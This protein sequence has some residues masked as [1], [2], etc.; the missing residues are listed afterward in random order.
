[1]HRTFC[2][3]ICLFAILLPF[4]ST[5]QA[6]RRVALVIGNGAYENASRLPNP[7]HD[8]KDVAAALRRS[9]FKT[10]VGLDL[11]QSQ[12]Q[13][14]AIR[15]SRA[16]READVALFY[17]S[18]HAMQFA[19]I[20]YLMPVDAKLR[21]EADLRRLTRTDEIVADLQQAKKLRILVL[22]ACRDNPLAE[23]LKRSIGR[24]RAATLGRGLARIESPEG[25]IVA[26]STQSGRT[27]DDGR[28]R[29]SPYTSAFLKHIETQ[30]EIGLV[31]RGISEEVYKS[32]DHKQLPELSLSLI[33]RFYLHGKPAAASPAAVS[34]AAAS[35]ATSSPGTT[36]PR[37]QESA[38]QAWELVKDTEDEAVFRAFLKEYPNGL[39]A[40]LAKARLRSLK[41]QK[42][43]API[44]PNT[45]GTGQP[46]EYLTWSTAVSKG[47]VE[48]YRDYLRRFPNGQHA[49]DIRQRLRQP[50]WTGQN[51]NTGVAANSSGD[52]QASEY[53]TWST[54][55]SKGT[56]YA[57]RDYLRRFPNGQHAHD[58]RQRLRQPGWTGQNPNT[59]V[60]AN[61]SGDDQASEYLTWSTA[62]SKGT[63]YAYRD[64]LRRFPNGMHAADIRKRLRRRGAR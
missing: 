57:Y 58:I 32:T 35:P 22:D 20:N 59:G 45:S 31:F 63:A 23:Q 55:V 44:A 16:A 41:K 4:S 1:M 53:L 52:D 29:N 17:Y 34:P 19:G 9:G 5:A 50:G 8:A 3:Y 60:A 46:S 2:L 28:G 7:K 36:A 61:S 33:G 39:Y 54:A 56:A 24:T 14:M 40:A 42:V 49:P 21:D 11:V 26:F 30:Q 43:N 18:G 47:S 12:M 62:V 27:A 48:A 15:F 25:M 37:P 64:Y 13:E 38:S 6:E 10:I 51:P